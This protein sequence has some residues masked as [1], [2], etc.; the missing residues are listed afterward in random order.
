MIRVDRS[1]FAFALALLGFG[2]MAPQEANAYYLY[3]FTTGFGR[4]QFTTASIIPDPSPSVPVDW[5]YGSGTL[6]EVSGGT[7]TFQ[8]GE[9]STRPPMRN[10]PSLLVCFPIRSVNMS[11]STRT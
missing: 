11:R 5:W 7:F 4:L 1:I 6:Y 8:N 10:S 3:T 9:T 2:V